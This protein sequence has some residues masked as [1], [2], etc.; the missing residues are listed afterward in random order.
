[1]AAL[2]NLYPSPLPL[3]LICLCLTLDLVCKSIYWT[4]KHKAT[5]NTPPSSTAII[6]WTSELLRW[7]GHS[8]PGNIS[9][10]Q[11]RTQ[12]QQE[13]QQR[14]WMLYQL[15]K[16]VGAVAEVGSAWAA[17]TA[18]APVKAVPAVE[19]EAAGAS[20]RLA[21]TSP[22]LPRWRQNESAKRKLKEKCVL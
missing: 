22:S 21:A 4:H 13:Q 8:A 6:T 2:S 14:R 20:I 7:S 9:E 15:W 10:E 5:F 17:E 1:M 16:T 12:Q 19:T 18:G 11:G 3:A